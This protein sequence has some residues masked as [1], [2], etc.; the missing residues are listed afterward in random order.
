MALH[1]YII[2]NTSSGTIT[3]AGTSPSGSNI[4][5]Q[6]YHVSVA[7]ENNQGY[8]EFTTTEVFATVSSSGITTTGITPC[9]VLVFGSYAAK[10]LVPITADSEE[11]ITHFSP[12]D[13]RGILAKNFRVTSLT[14]GASLDKFD[15]ALYPDSLWMPYMLIGNTPSVTTVPAT[16][17]SLLASTTV[18]ATMTL[19]SAPS[20]PGMFF[21]FTITGNTAVGTIV[22]NGKDQYGAT[23]TETINIPATNGTFYSTKRYSALTTPGSNEF[24]TTGM[25]GASVAVTGVFAWQ[26]SWTYDGVNNYQPYSACL[27]IFN[28]VFGYKLPY[29]ILSDGSFDWQKEKEIAFTGKGEAQDYLVIGDPASTS[30]GSNPFSTLAQPTSMPMTSWPA[31]FYIDLGSSVPFTTQDGSLETFKVDLTTGRKSFY[32]GDGQQRW[33]NATWDSEP[34][35]A[36]TA[37][38]VMQNYQQYL[39]Y[40]KPNTALLFGATFQGGFL[41]SIG[42]NTYFE[43]WSWTF[44]GK[45]DTYKPDMSKSPVEGSLKIMSEYSFAQ[46]F[47]FRL[48][49]TAQVPP[50]YVS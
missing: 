24:T 8:T 33:S 44:P 7:P 36:I 22:L 12:T 15:C 49:I 32:S 43:S 13:R 23:T 20:A 4:T 2:G 9:Q 19:T 42:S 25:S 30:A 40:F 16:P 37:T 1:F 31:S 17:T 48:S 38:M 26:Y 3:I 10:Y 46:G 47:A 39:T 18:A 28:G 35:F 14:K 45:I 21:I 50:T 6:T 41:G 11:H 34:D 5:S 27:E 29:T